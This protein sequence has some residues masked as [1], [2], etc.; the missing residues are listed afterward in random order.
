MITRIN[1]LSFVFDP[2]LGSEYSLGATAVNYCSNFR[3]RIFVQKS[4]ILR[5][6][7]P[8]R[9]IGA[10]VVARIALG[11][12]QV[13]L[14]GVGA[15]VAPQSP[16]A[17]RVAFQL[18]MIQCWLLTLRS[19]TT[20]IFWHVSY[21]QVLT[22]NPLHLTHR[23]SI[24]GPLGGRG[25]IYDITWLSYHRRFLNYVITRL[26][27]PLSGILRAMQ[28]KKT[29]LAHPGLTTRWDSNR[30]ILPAITYIQSAPV[31][32]DGMRQRTRVIVVGRN[33]PTKNPGISLQVMTA[34][35]RQ[36]PQYQFEIMGPGWEKR[37]IF[38][39]LHI[40]GALRQTEV[41]L[42]FS[43]SRLHIFLS[44]ELAGEV[45][46]QA[47]SMLC[48]TLCLEGFGADFLLNPS[49]K[50]KLN[51]KQ[52]SEEV[53]IADILRNALEIITDDHLLQN[54]GIRQRAYAE[55]WKLEA[56][57]FAIESFLKIKDI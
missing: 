36:Y 49:L 28:S 5:L 56:K 10:V 16:M 51:A 42:K 18:W 4:Q 34:L 38:D 32:K 53:V 31:Q 1:I 47:A 14:V 54:E 27:Y 52:K 39:N 26:L 25:I 2:K 37:Q 43:E 23:Y 21:A 6:G 41:L 30:N 12:R 20:E 7:V 40:F 3:V 17:S 29:L 45:S 57:N 55:R 13:T 9:H 15:W 8:Y 33:V 35:A 19:R 22:F 11:S 44:F 50:F 48:P 46:L 24:S